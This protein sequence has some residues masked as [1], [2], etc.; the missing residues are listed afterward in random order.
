MYMVRKNLCCDCKARKKLG[1][2]IYKEGSEP[3]TKL[4]CKACKRERTFFGDELIGFP[5]V[6]SVSEAE[7]IVVQELKKLVVGRES[8]YYIETARDFLFL[9]EL[10]SDMLE[11]E[12]LSEKLKFFIESVKE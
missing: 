3:L 4:W 8:G 11:G 12:S 1:Y 10:S 5:S 6:A 7:R 2:V 9:E